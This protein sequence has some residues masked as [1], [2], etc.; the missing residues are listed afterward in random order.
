MAE[1]LRQTVASLAAN[2]VATTLV[3]WVGTDIIVM[4]DRKLFVER[5]LIDFLYF[6]RIQNGWIEASK[7]L[8]ILKVI[9]F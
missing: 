7:F 4:T 2:T 6:R 5:I 3:K 1:T 8:N 9:F